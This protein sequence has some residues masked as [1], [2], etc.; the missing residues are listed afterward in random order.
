MGN[1]L[2]K[3]PNI[4]ILDIKKYNINSYLYYM[5]D[6]DLYYNGIK[7]YNSWQFDYKETSNVINSIKS[8]ALYLNKKV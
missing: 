4:K 2:S 8:E 5:N 6:I 3:Q 7:I 1:I